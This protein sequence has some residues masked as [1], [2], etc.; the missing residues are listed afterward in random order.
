MPLLVVHV[1]T[2]RVAS[3]NRR[4]P[5]WDSLVSDYTILITD[6]CCLPYSIEKG[7]DSVG[8]ERSIARYFAMSIDIAPKLSRKFELSGRFST[9]T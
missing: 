7:L 1:S 3:T 4:V 2:V 6:C 8:I 9:M 5:N